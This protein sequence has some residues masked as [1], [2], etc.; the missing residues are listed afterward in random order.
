MPNRHPSLTPLENASSTTR[1]V[2]P[3][4]LLAQSRRR[5]EKLALLLGGMSAFVLCLWPFGLVASRGVPIHLSVIL[6]AAILYAFVRSPRVSDA[7]ASNAGL[8]AEFALCAV[9]SVPSC[10]WF[11]AETGS[12]QDITWTCILI[13]VFPLIAPNH[14]RRIWWASL[15]A[16]ATS[17]LGVAIVLWAHGESPFVP[18]LINMSVSPLLCAVLAYIGARMIYQL[19]VEVE[20]RQQLGAYTLKERLGVG[21]MGEVWRASHRFLAR[22]AAVKL[23]KAEGVA[24]DSDAANTLLVRFG[25]EA[26]ATARLRSPHT[27]ELYDYGQA[28]DGTFYCVMELLDGFDLQ[29]LVEQHGALPAARVVHLLQHCC[30][31]LG[32]AHGAGM[33]HRDIKPAN[34]FACHYGPD[35]DFV[36]VLDFGLV[37]ERGAPAD[38]SLSVG[39]GVIGTPAFFAPEAVRGADLDGRAD[40]YALGCVAYWLLTAQLPFSEPTVMALAAAHLNAKPPLPSSRIAGPIDAQ[41]EAVVMACLAKAPGDRPATA[42]ALAARL[43]ACDVPAWTQAD[44]AAWWAAARPST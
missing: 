43:T 8:I 28:E 24:A 4:A 42:E 25:L 6:V 3:R 12:F 16:G 19:G 10:Y 38:P 18:S 26:Q 32:E 29:Q 11:Y 17:P 27:V 44:A 35:F 13:A 39:T 34:I 23:I 1:S 21:G 41:L 9:I 36:K 30:H 31:S 33:V 14:P 2:L 40:I 20:R 22:P 37:K 5:L 15:A 7:A